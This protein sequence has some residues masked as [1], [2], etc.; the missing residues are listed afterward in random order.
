MSDKVYVAKIGKSVGLKGDLKLFIV[1]D[2]PEQ[3]KKDAVFTTNKKIELKIENFN[4]KNSTVKFYGFDDVDEAKKLTNSLLYTSK[5]ESNK[6]IKLEKDQ[7]FWYDI[8]DCEV[9]EN[10]KIL[11]IVKDVQRFAVDDF[12][13]IT[14]SEELVKKEYPKSFLIPYIDR[15][16]IKVDIKNKTI[17]TQDCLEI[18]QHS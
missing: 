14:T 12:L 1:S 7:Y 10:D 6:N 15:Y 16:I 13:F 5:E 17:H 3:F 8:I 4:A 18:L 2:F 11:G 9:K